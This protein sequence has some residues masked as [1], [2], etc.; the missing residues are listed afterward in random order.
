MRSMR[1]TLPLSYRT[2]QAITALLNERCW[3]RRLLG[4]VWCALLAVTGQLVVLIA[5]PR[6]VVW[7]RLA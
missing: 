2:T 3:W 7:P 1:Q 5:A 6:Y 4:L